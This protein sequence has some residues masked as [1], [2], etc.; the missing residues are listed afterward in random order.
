MV[1]TLTTTWVLLHYA[2][3]VPS[4]PLVAKPSRPKSGPDVAA[5][6]CYCVSLDSALWMKRHRK[7]RI[8]KQ[9]WDFRVGHSPSALM[10]AQ[11]M[12]RHAR[13]GFRNARGSFQF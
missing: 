6:E 7:R 4:S 12:R 11:L 10:T 3:S 1:K 9:S 8:G 13:L 2:L 5:E